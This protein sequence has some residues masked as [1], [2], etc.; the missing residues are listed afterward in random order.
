MA[1]GEIYGRAIYEPEMAKCVWDAQ[2]PFAF[3]VQQQIWDGENL[4]TPDRTDL[5]NEI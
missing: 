5:L 1:N 2:S 4:I 3:S